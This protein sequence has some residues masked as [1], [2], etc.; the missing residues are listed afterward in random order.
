MLFYGFGTVLDI[1]CL[2]TGVR[3]AGW[4]HPGHPWGN[5]SSKTINSSFTHNHRC[6]SCGTVL[7]SRCILAGV[8]CCATVH[9][10]VRLYTLTAQQHYRILGLFGGFGGLEGHRHLS[11]VVPSSC[12]C[13]RCHVCVFVFPTSALSPLKNPQQFWLKGFNIRFVC[14]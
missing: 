2:L 13:H 1:R 10:L 11:V 9:H 4:A 8:R 3:Y 14:I 7:D 12:H 6:G 5:S